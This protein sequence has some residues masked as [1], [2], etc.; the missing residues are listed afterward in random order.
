MARAESERP[1]AAHAT[2]VVD[3]PSDD[4]ADNMEE[5]SVSSRELAVV[6]SESGPSGGLPK[7]DLEWP[8]P[9]DPSKVWFVLRD[10]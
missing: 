8:C 6:P 2:E 10:S 7:G 3:I 5:L 1:T 4:E 9:E